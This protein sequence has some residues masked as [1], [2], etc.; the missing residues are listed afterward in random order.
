MIRWLAVIAVLALSCPVE[1]AQRRSAKVLREFQRQVPCPA[2]GL[3]KGPCRGWERDHRIPLC[4]G[5]RDEPWQLQWLTIR[6]HDVKTVL[7][8]RM[9]AAVRALR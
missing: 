4:L 7:D 1:A 9:C 5:G 3:K 8:L 2:T 6:D